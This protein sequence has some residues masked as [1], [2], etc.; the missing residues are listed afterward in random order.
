VE[1]DPDSKWILREMVAAG[2]KSQPGLP[3]DAVVS[4]DSSSLQRAQ[5]LLLR[6]PDGVELLERIRQLPDTRQHFVFHWTGVIAR[7]DS[8]L[9]RLFAQHVL[10][11]FRLMDEAG[12]EAWL[13]HAM[14]SYDKHGLGSAITALEDVE[15][16][17]IEYPERAVQID[18]EVMQGVLQSLVMGLGGRPLNILAGDDAYT[19]TENI[20][21]PANIREF[22]DPRMNRALYKALTVFLWA[23]NVYGTWRLGN[24]EQLSG[25]P[26]PVTSLPAF[27][28]LERLRIEAQLA[29]DLPGQVRAFAELRQAQGLDDKLP[30][31]WQQA[32]IRLSDC[33]STTEDSLELAVQLRNGPLPPTVCYQ[34]QLY[35]ARVRQVL[36]RRV[37]RERN[38]LRRSLSELQQQL[39]GPLAEGSSR[40]VT[41]PTDAP[42]PGGQFSLAAGDADDAEGAAA[43]ELRYEGRPVAPPAEVTGLLVSI[44]Q[45]LGAVPGDY[46][47]AAADVPY[48][49]ATEATPAAEHRQPLHYADGA[50][51]YPEWDYIRQRYRPDYCILREHTVPPGDAAFVMHTLQ[52]YRGPLASI[53][54]SFEAMLGEDR[55]LR[56]QSDGDDIDLDALV[57]GQ[58]DVAR[59]LEM[60]DRV[61]QRRHRIDRNIAVMLMVD[62]SGSTRGWVNEAEREALV[63]LCQ[64]L[65]TL[66][67]RYAIYGFS[68]RT[69]SRC[70]IYHIKHFDER[71]SRAVGE[72]ISGMRPQ[73]YTRMGVAIRHLSGLL[74]DVPAR[75]KLLVALSDGKPEDYGS[76]RGRYGIEDTRRALLEARRYGIHAFCITIDREGGDYLPH[77]YGTANYAVIDEVR[78]LPLKVAD[79]YRR[80][81]T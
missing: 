80:L 57:E 48:D 14:D 11:A 50:L 42:K 9:A 41:D 3:P 5:G 38:R 15:S 10:A 58:A 13:F 7:S 74:R 30:A 18:L 59:G 8:E 6:H 56:R 67:D 69:H 32:A 40:A 71:Y 43:P 78:K 66:G 60:N 64:A 35:P 36:R 2:S 29:V 27:A 28:S 23:Q 81:T 47:V 25:L 39:T 77:M 79:I 70:A 19:D 63:L 65:E 51:T 46:L 33:N 68:G 20:Y 37:A 31:G 55:M 73:T 16:F 34:G 44:H 24:L 4:S 53:R 49:A 76:Y 45:D 22:R 61:Y 52:K 17:A 62:M 54:R 72:R 12:V 21:L 75:N 26:D 1:R